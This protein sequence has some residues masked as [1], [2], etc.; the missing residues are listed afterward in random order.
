MSAGYGP[1]Y[2]GGI[3]MKKQFNVYKNIK[4]DLSISIGLLPIMSHDSLIW[5]RSKV[6]FINEYILRYYVFEKE[7][8][9]SRVYLRFN[10]FIIPHSLNFSYN[11]KKYYN[12]YAGVGTIA[13]VYDFLKHYSLGGTCYCD[14]DMYKFFSL[15]ISFSYTYNNFLCGITFSK[16]LKD[17]SFANHDLKGYDTYYRDEEVK[18]FKNKLFV[19]FNLGYYFERKRNNKK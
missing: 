7:E 14:I 1:L 6:I 3:G 5:S 4:F 16:F 8:H 2:G 11:F 15:N 19:A 18:L 13:R 9:V 10:R 17:L 12:L